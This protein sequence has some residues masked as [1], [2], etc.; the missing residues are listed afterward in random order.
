MEENSVIHISANT[1]ESNGDQLSIKEIDLP[2]YKYG[3]MFRHDINGYLKVVFK[4]Q[5]IMNIK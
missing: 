2:L 3:L 4:L 5:S 1:S